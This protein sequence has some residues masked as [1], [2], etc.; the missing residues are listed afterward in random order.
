[1][2]F[3]RCV[4]L[5]SLL[6][7]SLLPT[8]RP[9]GFVSVPAIYDTNTT[10]VRTTPTLISALVQPQYLTNDPYRQSI[11]QIQSSTMAPY[12]SLLMLAGLA[13]S[14]AA[15]PL[16]QASRSEVVAYEKRGNSRR[17][18]ASNTSVQYYQSIP[19]N[20][21]STLIAG[22]VTSQSPDRNVKVWATF[23]LPPSTP[24]ATFST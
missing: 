14:V 19:R 7:L 20:A 11:N 1:M 18:Q 13:A 16:R 22:Q 17:N 3:D 12:T 2:L 10:H 6:V 15:T 4:A 5:R 9:S 24:L 8:D 23:W 21:D